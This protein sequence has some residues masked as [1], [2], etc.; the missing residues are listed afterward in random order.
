MNNFLGLMY[1]LKHKNITTILIDNTFFEEFLQTN[2]LKHNFNFVNFNNMQ[3]VNWFTTNNLTISNELGI[4]IDGHAG[5]NGN[6]QISQI[7]LK[8]LINNKF[9][10]KSDYIKII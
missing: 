1:F 4:K 6:I 10:E 9:I 5:L 7:V 8:Y 2:N 3:M